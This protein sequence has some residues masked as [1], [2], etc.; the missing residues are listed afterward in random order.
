MTVPGGIYPMLY[1][2][3]DA[4][5]GVDLAAMRTQ[6]RAAIRGGAHGVGVLGLATEVGKLSAGERQ[7]ILDC[8]AAEVGGRLPLAVTVAEAD[9]Q[10]AIASA[11]AA[12]DADAAFV[13]LQPP[14]VRGAPEADQ[15]RYYGSV[16]DALS[17]PVAIQNAPEYLGTSLTVSG[18]ARLSAQHPNVSVIK[19][20]G[21]ALFVRDLME[22]TAGRLAVFN[23]RCGLELTD[24]LRAGCHGMIPGIETVDVQSRIYE[25][26]RTG[27]PADAAEADRLYA[28]ILPLLVFIIQSI[29]SLLCYGKRVAARRLDLGPVYDRAPA[30]A[31]N[32]AGLAWA[33]RLSAALGPL[34]S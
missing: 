11:R 1:A 12:Q 18:I 28:T 19:A 26:M 17:I 21:S 20:E 15:I 7:A 25:L 5:G 2:F 3:F 4:K 8:V 31:P 22:A 29:D 9:V 6:A 24:N 23:G 32:P 33:D 10:A 30:L 27:D 14:P 13:I 34:A 16:A